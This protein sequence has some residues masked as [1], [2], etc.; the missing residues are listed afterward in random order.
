VLDRRL[1]PVP[2]GVAGEIYQGGPGRARGYHRRPALTAAR[3]VP[4]PFAGAGPGDGD[5]GGRR[6]YRTGDRGRYLADGNLEFLER[7]D[8]QVKIRGNRVELGEIEAALALHPKVR[9]CA[10]A[11]ATLPARDG[12]PPERRLVAYVVPTEEAPPEVGELHR[13]LKQR[14]PPYMVPAALVPIAAL[15]L[16][17]SGKV[18]RLALAAKGRPGAA[19]AQG[20]IAPH[21]EVERRLAESW[22]RVLWLDPDVV[23]HDD[24]FDLGGHSL[25]ASVLVAEVEK[26][27]ETRLPA[28]AL[29]RLTTVSE[30]AGHLEPMVA[31]LTDT[32]ARG[33]AVPPPDGAAGSRQ[34]SG[35]IHHR[36]LAFTAGWRG[37]RAAPDGGLMVGLNLGG[38]RPP[39]FWCLQGFDELEHLAGHLGPGQPVF[40]MR[41]GH[42]AMQFT[43][44]NIRALAAHYAGEILAAE[45]AG[46]YLVGGNCQGAYVAW[47]IAE[48]LRR[49]GRQ[50]PLLALQLFDYRHALPYGGRV[51]LFFGADAAERFRASGA[52][53]PVWSELY[54]GGFTLDPISGTERW[55]FVEPHVQDFTGKLAR[56]IERALAAPVPAAPAAAQAAASSRGVVVLAAPG[57]GSPVVAELVRRLWPDAD[58]EEDAAAGRRVAAI[59]QELL[60][61]L[62]R[63]W[64]DPRPLPGE[65][66]GGA[67]AAAARTRLRE[68]IARLATRPRWVLDEPHLGRLL[69]LWDGLLPGGVEVHFLHVVRAPAA[70]A[71]A[72]AERDGLPPAEGLVVWLLHALDA[73]LATR[74]RPRS[75]L[76]LE[77]LADPLADP[78]PGR[79]ARALGA[80]A[81]PVDDL[82]R[83]LAAALAE[84]GGGDAGPAGDSEA[85]RE[86]LRFQPWAAAA[87]RASN[88]LSK[89]T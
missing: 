87:A 8:G 61:A 29:F 43:V 83:R 34:L 17:P 26:A 77:A 76:Q 59:H 71:A 13:F 54:P 41:S 65:A 40:G 56:R 86:A 33:L 38:H 85:V 60:A 67:A 23:I 28:G 5:A 79:A 2:V 46:P 55:H 62:G 53:E 50:V 72:L 89:M 63:R 37:Q 44:D 47:A 12:V 14:L 64:D 30:L 21:N 73:E 84:L 66:F 39:L 48:E 57:G 70:V 69:P 16:T 25:L 3:F 35:E 58:P 22:K 81:G 19:P 4:D 49:R 32:L 74:E 51:A 52:P 88:T 80:A 1:E 24:F 75:W 9:E 78:L 6:L 15:P 18:D 20:Y 68:E 36:L 42:L 31:M 11:V 27:F 10:V 45:P 82:E 7:I